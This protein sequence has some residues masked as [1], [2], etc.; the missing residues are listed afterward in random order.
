MSLPRWFMA[1][2]QITRRAAVVDELGHAIFIG[3]PWS[4][5]GGDSSKII[6]HNST[7][8]ETQIWFIS[9]NQI[10]RRGTVVDESGNAIFIGAPWSI[11]GA[12]IDEI[13]WYN[14]ST[15][16]TQVWFMT[17]GSAGRATRNRGG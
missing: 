5:V 14:R 12:D 10:V 13:V 6:W 3:L 9:G 2:D 4:I 8:N 16:E 1:G 15:N 7:T 11:V 17:D